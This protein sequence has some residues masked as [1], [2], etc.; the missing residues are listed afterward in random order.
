MQKSNFRN[1]YLYEFKL[2][3]SASQT[4]KNINTVWGKGSVNE[5][6]VQRWFKKFQH[7]D[8]SLEDKKGRG[9][10]SV[11]KHDQLRTVIESDPRKTSRQVADELQVNQST[12]VRHLHQIG[13]VNMLDK[14][15]PHE[16]NQNQRN[17]RFEIASALLLRNKNDPFLDRIVTCDEKWIL[18]DN[19]RRSHQWLD[20]GEP[21]KHFPK[22]NIHQRKIM[23][24]VWWCVHGLIHHSFLDPGKTITADI[25]CHQIDEM[26]TK[27][28]IL[29]PALVNRKGPIILHDNAR[30][31]IAHSTLR[32]LNELGYE[33]LP[34]PAYSPD[35]APTDFYFFKHLQDYLHNKCFEKRAD[36]ENAFLAF[37][38]S[39]SMDFYAKGIY[40]LVSCWEECVKSEGCYFN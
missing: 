38:E 34:H 27:L 2:G 11:L 7:N 22:P 32:K 30:P 9:R 19:R 14:W 23:V 12:I 13:K 17:H 21:P 33:S 31:H 29:S 20:R 24:T 40:K 8:F 10:P 37:A 15:V 39:R 1:I 18:Y 4:A 3:R 16:L 6:T 36:A 5:C 26:H 35:L 25:Y 28:Q